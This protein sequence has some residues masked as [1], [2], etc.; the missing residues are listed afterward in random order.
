[1]TF[2]GKDQSN[3]YVSSEVSGNNYDQCDTERV[4]EPAA[5]VS[6]E[7]ICQVIYA[8][9]NYCGHHCTISVWAYNICSL[10]PTS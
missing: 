2:S 5:E 10:G 1:M 4:L 8:H 3:E 9:Q 6:Q 7:R